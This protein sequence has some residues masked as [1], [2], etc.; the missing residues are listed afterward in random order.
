MNN[1]DGIQVKWSK[2]EHDWIIHYPNKPD[3]WLTHGFVRGD[4]TFPEWIKELEQ[5]GYDLTTLKLS[6]KLKRDGV[7]GS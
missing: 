3:G 4:D 1:E 5:R 7:N 6:V 2:R